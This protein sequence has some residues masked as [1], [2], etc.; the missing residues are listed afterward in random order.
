[1]NPFKTIQKYIKRYFCIHYG[2]KTPLQLIQFVTNRC[3]ARCRHCF[4]W[5]ELNSKKNELTL[6]QFKKIAKSLKYPL[7]YLILTGGEPF[8]R[9]DIAEICQIFSKIN[10]TKTI[11]IP[12]NGFLTDQIY[13]SVKNILDVCDS[14]IVIQVSL[15]GLEKTHDKIRGV[16]G[17]FKKAVETIKKLKTLENI[18]IFVLTV[19]SNYNLN[20]IERLSNYLENKLK[21][22]HSFEI[23]RGTRF[24]KNFGLSSNILNEFSPKNKNF[25][26]PTIKDLEKIYPIIKKIYKTQQKGIGY[27]TSIECLNST[28]NILKDHKKIVD[29]LAGKIIG[30]IY[31]NGDV[32][33][34]ELT[35]PIGNLKDFGFDFYKIWNSKKANEMRKKIKNC[36]CT[37][38]CFLLPSII[39]NPEFMLKSIIKNYLFG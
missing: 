36:Y 39:Y 6:D 21:V 19:I 20:E 29:C 10:K 17:M 5:K 32:G 37:H 24:M 9:N 2:L 11:Q 38:T 30:V 13:S 23:I 18:N 25:S 22:R 27:I 12:T 8:L 3:N 15:D 7:S 26:P 33:L 34:C 1:M 28:I 31:A 4:L 35:V 14:T 16:D